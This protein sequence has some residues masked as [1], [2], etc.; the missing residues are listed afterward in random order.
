MAD[1]T[2]PS[3][4]SAQA[5]SADG[6][7][8]GPDFLRSVGVLLL[9]L[10]VGGLLAGHGAQKLLGWFEGGGIAATESQMESLGL[11]PAWPWARF[12]AL[13]ELGGGLLTMLGLLNP[14][15]PLLATGS[16]LVATFKVHAGKP[17]W[18]TKGGAEL[19]ITNLAALAAVMAIGPGSLSL[20]RALGVR[21]PRILALPGLLTVGGLT[22]LTLQASANGSP[23][24]GRKATRRRAKP[25]GRCD[26]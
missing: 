14:V 10:T 18:N 9:R 1:D 11:T 6:T 23:K 3:E 13:S 5:M 26:V 2:S 16:M 24:A 12:A 8:R 21:L 4:V 22:W 19:P 25:E 20:D 7:R 15:G 17:I